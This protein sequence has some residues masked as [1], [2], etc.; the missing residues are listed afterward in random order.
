[1]EKR[2]LTAREGHGLCI[3]A[4]KKSIPAKDLPYRMTAH[5]PLNLFHGTIAVGEGWR[6][7][8]VALRQTYSRRAEIDSA[9][10]A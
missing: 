6:V 1:M 9:S 3:R 8:R 2:R 10:V 5:Q 4:G 7:S